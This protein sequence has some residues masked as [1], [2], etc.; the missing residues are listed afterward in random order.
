MTTRSTRAAAL[1][2]LARRDHSLRE[3]RERLGRQGHPPEAIEAALLELS[4]RGWLDET[5]SARDLAS[6]LTRSRGLGPARV[7]DTLARKRRLGEEAVGE[8]MRSLQ[9]EG[10]DWLERAHAALRGRPRD[11][12][13]RDRLLRFLLRRGFDA[14][15]ARRA[16][17]EHLASEPDPSAEGR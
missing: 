8:A 14:D 1:A 3:L 12:A 11:P 17:R 15:T 4:A 9:D 6:S 5:R 10:V 2:L 16:V 7:R 13:H